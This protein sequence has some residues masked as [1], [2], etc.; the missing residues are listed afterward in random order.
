[1]VWRLES[2]IFCT[3]NKSFNARWS[4]KWSWILSLYHLIYRLNKEEFILSS[5]NLHWAFKLDKKNG[6]FM[7]SSLNLHWAFKLDKWRWNR[8][9]TAVKNHY[10]RIW[11]AKT[12]IQSL[13]RHKYRFNT[14]FLKVRSNCNCMVFSTFSTFSL[15]SLKNQLS[16][17]A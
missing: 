6:E 4:T 1:M 2:K 15:Q 3:Y 8:T 17:E 11:Q 13:L 16:N 10:F 9:N 5:L 12:C 7:L 14:N